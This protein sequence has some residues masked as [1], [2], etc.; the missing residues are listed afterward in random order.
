MPKMAI[1][2]W[3]LSLGGWLPAVALPAAA[4]LSGSGPVVSTLPGTGWYCYLAAFIIINPVLE[5][6]SQYCQESNKELQ[7]LYTLWYM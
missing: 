1:V 6:Q 4:R 3:Y 5:P 2:H 7:Q